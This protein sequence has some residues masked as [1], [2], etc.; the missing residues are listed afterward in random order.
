MTSQFDADAFFGALIISGF[1][2]ADP[3]NFRRFLGEYLAASDPAGA[4]AAQAL[5]RTEWQRQEEKILAILAAD[6]TASKGLAPGQLHELSAADLRLNRESLAAGQDLPALAGSLLKLL[7]NMRAALHVPDQPPTEAPPASGPGRNDAFGLLSLALFGQPQA[8]APVKY[9]L[10]WNIA[11]R[12]WVHWD[13]NTRSPIGRNLLA[14]LGLGA[15]LTGKRGCLDFAL[16]Q[17]HTTLSED[18]RP[19]RYPWAIDQAVAA[20]GARHYQSLC[21]TC[22]SGAESDQRLHDPAE[23]GTD[24]RRAAGFTPLQAQRF[25]TFLSEL[26]IPGYTPPKEPG[27]R[28]TQRYWAPS[29]GGVWARSPYLHNGSVRTMQE[30][31]S[32]AASRAKSFRRGSRVYDAA[33]MGYTDEGAYLLDTTSGGNSNAGHEYGA[34]LPNAEKLE[35]IEYLKTL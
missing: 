5:L 29:L 20:R 6:P 35:L 32:P 31:L 2:T 28:S 3:A 13:G 24:P 17:R 16:V 26:E 23:I 15:P 22:H 14:A 4:E 27:I 1:R 11:H 9:G 34:E 18:L 7:H 25:D 19:P 21:A 33:Q 12:Y 8:Y 30:L 10:V